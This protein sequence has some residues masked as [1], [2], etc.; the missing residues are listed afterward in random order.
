LKL[1]PY[2]QAKAAG[3]KYYVSDVPCKRG[4]QGPRYVSG[5]GCYPCR[6]QQYQDKRLVHGA[7][8]RRKAAEWRK[9]NRAKIQRDGWIRQGMPLPTRPCPE[10]CENCGRVQTERALALDHCH[11]T[12][13][14]RGW[15][16]VK[17]NVGI[18]KLGDTLEAIERTADYLRRAYA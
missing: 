18:G 12:K 14:F 6:A 5:Y 16:C 10:A 9:E 4:H 2:R 8:M 11:E 3:H 7:E 15:L 1:L 17:C 13:R